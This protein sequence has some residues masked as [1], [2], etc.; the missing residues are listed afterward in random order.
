MHQENQRNYRSSIKR[1]MLLAAAAASVIGLNR[2]A[3]CANATWSAAPA[4]SNWNAPNWTTASAPYTALP[5]DALIFGTSSVTGLNNDFAA[6][7][8]FGGITFNS[9]ASAFALSGN[10]IALSGP[11]AVN[12][13]SGV[14]T[15]NLNIAGSAT[16][17]ISMSS[18]A[19][20]TGNNLALNGSVSVATLTASGVNTS[21]TPSNI[22]T[23]ASGKT[24]TVTGGI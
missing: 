22:L 11:I 13:G 6:G 18:A 3:Q 15:I 16:S 1:T 24:L 5:G 2:S 23:I 21:A 20:N 7:T 8:S 9:G 17:G 12:S 19:S 4:G 10:D 14:Q